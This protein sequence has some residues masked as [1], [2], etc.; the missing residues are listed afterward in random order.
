MPLGIHK[1]LVIS[2]DDLQEQESPVQQQLD[3][4]LRRFQMEVFES[5]GGLLVVMMRI[6]VDAQ[7]LCQVVPSLGREGGLPGVNKS[8]PS[9][10]PGLQ[11]SG[12]LQ[13]ARK[14]CR[15]DGRG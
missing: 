10:K 1:P 5:L 12:T 8:C 9:G 15:I 2:R 3:R 7:A 4:L 6:H 11:F 14:R 13:D